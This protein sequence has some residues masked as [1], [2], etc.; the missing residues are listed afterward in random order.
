M[1]RTVVEGDRGAMLINIKRFIKALPREEWV[2]STE[3]S[4]SDRFTDA[5]LS[6]YDGNKMK[7]ALDRLG[8]LEV[9]G[10]LRGL[11]Y[12][13]PAK[14]ADVDPDHLAQEVLKMMDKI[15]EEKVSD[16]ET[17]RIL[18]GHT[19]VEPKRKYTKRK[20]K[21]PQSFK[22][23]IAALENEKVTRSCYIPGSKVWVMYDNKPKEVTIKAVN[24]VFNSETG[25]F[26]RLIYHVIVTWN[27]V[28]TWFDIVYG[29]KEMLFEAVKRQFW[30]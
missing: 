15:K 12:K 1:K 13:F 14:L 7:Q 30:D 25:A 21:T 24:G 8:F 2:A 18:A 23:K 28:E 20:P 11:R 9:D 19:D 6:Q 17:K 27:E 16:N 10:R 29:T 5:G 3:K 4:L 26:E 22:D